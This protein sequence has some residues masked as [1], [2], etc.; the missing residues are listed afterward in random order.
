LEGRFDL[1]ALLKKFGLGQLGWWCSQ[2]GVTGALKQG[3]SKAQQ[4]V[5]GVALLG[6]C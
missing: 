6:Y 5:R 1:K 3:N 2:Q 4:P